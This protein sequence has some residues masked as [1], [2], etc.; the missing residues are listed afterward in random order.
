MPALHGWSRSAAV[1]LAGLGLLAG[2]LAHAGWGSATP[3][4]GPEQAAAPE[5][6]AGTSTGAERLHPGGAVSGSLLVASTS[7]EP[8]V[9][10]SGAFAPAT[11]ATPGCAAT[12]VVFALTVEPSSSMPLV[13]P[14]AGSSAALGWT[15]FLAASDDACQDAEFRS[16]LTLDG[17]LVGTAVALAGSLPAPGRP[18]GGRTTSTR[19]AIRWPAAPAP[20][21][22]RPSYLLERAPAGTTSWSPA[23]G[24]SAS[25]PLRRPACNDTG[26]APGTAYVYRATS[27][28]GSWRAVGRTSE[29]VTTRRA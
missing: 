20:P 15:A 21:T 12:G 27:V 23:C 1:S 29:A 25:T 3:G 13:V 9:V 16:A 14:A 4:T 10:T 22:A 5:L 17:Q 11:T 7:A 26:L 19:A 28:L 8:L 18:Y 24:S 6:S 2:A